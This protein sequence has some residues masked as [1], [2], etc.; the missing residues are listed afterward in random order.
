VP[1]ACSGGYGTFPEIPRMSSFCLSSLPCLFGLSPDA[2]GTDGQPF[3]AVNTE[4]STNNC[5]EFKAVF[6]VFPGFFLKKLQQLFS[7]R[8]LD[9]FTINLPLLT[10]LKYFNNLSVRGCALI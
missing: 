5:Y 7:E 9:Y 8:S 10:A 4:W 6:L 3:Y 2:H 1:A